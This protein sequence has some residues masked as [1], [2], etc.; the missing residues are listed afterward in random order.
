[1]RGS[2]SVMSIR[3]VA[4]LNA[5]SLD[6]DVI[7]RKASV[8]CPT[9]SGSLNLDATLARIFPSSSRSPVGSAE[10]RGVERRYLEIP[11]PGS[12][13]TQNDHMREFCSV[14]PRVRDSVPAGPRRISPGQPD[15]WRRRL[16][17]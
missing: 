14:F 10:Y 8:P 2:K 4:A 5:A 12:P 16:R 6:G 3:A 9:N 13:R 17:C 1:M 11:R 15:R 7:C